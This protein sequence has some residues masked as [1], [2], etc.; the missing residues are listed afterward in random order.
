MLIFMLTY[1]VSFLIIGKVFYILSVD[2]ISKANNKESLLFFERSVT[3]DKHPHPIKQDY[4]IESV[5][6]RKYLQ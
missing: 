6:I 4:W 5:Y 1:G 3:R 2:I